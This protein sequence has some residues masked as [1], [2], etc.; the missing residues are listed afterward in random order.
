LRA[1][2][3]YSRQD[4]AGLRHPAAVRSSRKGHEAE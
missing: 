2:Q 4:V 1:R 3:E